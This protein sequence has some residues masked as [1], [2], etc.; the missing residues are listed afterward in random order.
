M[1]RKEMFAGAQE[2]LEKCKGSPVQEGDDEDEEDE[3]E[4]EEE[5]AR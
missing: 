4:D 2:V 5:E 3:E 1:G